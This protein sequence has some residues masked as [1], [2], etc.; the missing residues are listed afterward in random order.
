MITWLHLYLLQIMTAF[1]V[2]VAAAGAAFVV[3]VSFTVHII[4]FG[5]NQ[6]AEG[7][8]PIRPFPSRPDLCSGG[9]GGGCFFLASE[10]LGRMFNHSFPACV[11]LLFFLFFFY[12]FK[13]EISSRTLIPPSVPGS[14]HSSS[15]S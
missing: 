15:A 14:V 13:V 10:D 3:F 8:V 5:I 6:G 12:F 4:D 1:V 7:E 9:G 11:F 2:A